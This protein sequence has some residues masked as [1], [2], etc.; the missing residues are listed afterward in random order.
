MKKSCKIILKYVCRT[1]RKIPILYAFYQNEKIHKIRK[2]M[3]YKSEKL[4]TTLASKVST[5]ANPFPFPRNSR[6]RHSNL[7]P[8]DRLVP[9]PFWSYPNVLEFT[10]KE[11][12]RVG[13]SDRS[14]RSS[15]EREIVID[16]GKQ[17]NFVGGG[18][19]ENSRMKWWEGCGIVEQRRF[20]M[21]VASLVKANVALPSNSPAATCIPWP[22]PYSFH[23]SRIC[24]SFLYMKHEH[25]TCED[26]KE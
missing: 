8:L 25:S 23:L 21:M 26:L 22:F 14:V 9:I 13:R 16:G 3:G 1:L 11:C 6:A 2:R 10:L 18:I 5:I 15:R 24:L 12:N 20:T 19:K 7:S 4:R 17:R